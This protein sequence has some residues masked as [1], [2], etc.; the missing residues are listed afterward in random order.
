MNLRDFDAWRASPVT[1]WFLETYLQGYAEALAEDNGRAVGNRGKDL[2]EDYMILAKQAGFVEGVELAI[3]ADPFTE[4][5]EEKEDE[6]ESDRTADN[7][8]NGL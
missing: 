2:Y 4:E 3:T 7:H 6:A 1:V 5:R 8:K